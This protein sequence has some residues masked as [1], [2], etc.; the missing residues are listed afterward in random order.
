EYGQD[1]DPSPNPKRSAACNGVIGM[2][3]QVYGTAEMKNDGDAFQAG[4]SDSPTDGCVAGTNVEYNPVGYYYRVHIAQPLSGK[5]TIE[6]FDP[7]MV[8]VGATCGN[9]R[10]DGTALDLRRAKNPYHNSQSTPTPD[11][12]YAGGVNSPFCTGD[13]DSESDY[14]LPTTTTTFA[15]SGP[16]TV[17]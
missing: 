14:S 4:G 9:I 10:S 2:W 5:L 8:D 13:Y 11:D 12:R 17:A 6:A 16:S 3:G 1:P 15:V 7:M